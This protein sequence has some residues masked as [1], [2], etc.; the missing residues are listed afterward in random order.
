[1]AAQTETQYSPARSMSIGDEEGLLNDIEL[2]DNPNPGSLETGGNGRV[3]VVGSAMFLGN[4]A[5]VPISRAPTTHRD[6]WY[7]GAFLLHFIFVFLLFFFKD[8]DN[9]YEES[10]I[11]HAKAA[12]WANILMIVD[13]LSTCILVSFR[14]L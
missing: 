12:S 2:S 13:L 1:M 10:V 4:K 3:H 11:M 5:P 7:A 14:G 9:L 6:Y 8:G